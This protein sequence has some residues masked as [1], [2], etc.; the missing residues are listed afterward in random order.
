MGG[1]RSTTG[2]AIMAERRLPVK[3]AKNAGAPAGVYFML[4]RN[5]VGERCGN[6]GS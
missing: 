1:F 3:P 5:G 2:A 6:I 4:A